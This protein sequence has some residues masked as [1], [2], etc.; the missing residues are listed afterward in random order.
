MTT[1]F[2]LT[3]MG[4]SFFQGRVPQLVEALNKIGTALTQGVAHLEKLNKQEE[5]EDRLDR[6]IEYFDGVD[7]LSYDSRLT[8]PH[9]VELLRHIKNGEPD[10]LAQ[11]DQIAAA[12]EKCSE[13]RLDNIDDKKKVIRAILDEMDA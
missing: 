3:G 11:A 2:Y 4:K 8:A 10:R 12:L 1:P 7:D 6:M 13:C 9:V 5:I